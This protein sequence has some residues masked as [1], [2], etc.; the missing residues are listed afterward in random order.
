VADWFAGSDVRHL[1]KIATAYFVTLKNPRLPVA[2]RA[3][4]I[5]SLKPHVD[6]IAAEQAI[7]LVDAKRLE[8][9]KQFNDVAA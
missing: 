2:E 7:E 5:N 8:A 1:E 9:L 3:R 6:I 4:K